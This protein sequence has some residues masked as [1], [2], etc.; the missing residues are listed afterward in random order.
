MNTRGWKS[1]R[2]YLPVAPLLLETVDE[3]ERNCT[4]AELERIDSR[5]RDKLLSEGWIICDEGREDWSA[6]PPAFQEWEA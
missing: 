1:W 5:A 4:P 2:Y 3:C 6:I